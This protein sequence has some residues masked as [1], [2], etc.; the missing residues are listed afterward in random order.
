MNIE[1]RYQSRG[2]NTEGAAEKIAAEFAV[3]AKPVPEA[4]TYFGSQLTEYVDVLFLGGGV[5]WNQPHRDLDY[6]IR[7]LDPKMVGQIVFFSTNGGFFPH[8]QSVNHQLAVLARAHG[9]TVAEETVQINLYLHGFSL[10]NGSV[11]WDRI[12]LSFWSKKGGNIPEKQT[13]QLC[14]FA[15]KLGKDLQLTD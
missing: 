3:T 6:Y 5:Y 7:Q 1:V 13:R 8:G 4:Y 12:R 11:L 10:L 2:G 15:D 14:D 9:L